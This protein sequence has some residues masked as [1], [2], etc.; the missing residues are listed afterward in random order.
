MAGNVVIPVGCYLLSVL[1]DKWATFLAFAPPEAG[2]SQGRLVRPDTPAGL[3]LKGRL[4][5]IPLS[6]TAVLVPLDT[7]TLVAVQIE[8]L[9]AQIAITLTDLAAPVPPVEIQEY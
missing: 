7:L 5:L 2:I 4:F 9:G 6:T 1:R 3:G 8:Y